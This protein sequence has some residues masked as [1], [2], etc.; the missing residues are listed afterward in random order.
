M[1]SVLMAIFLAIAGLASIAQAAERDGAA[2]DPFSVSIRVDATA[3]SARQA[4]ERAMAQGRPLAWRELFRRITRERDWATEPRLTD[5]ELLGLILNT[6]AVNERR[7]TT[8][9]LADVTFHFNPAAVRQVLFE[10]NIAFADG[11]ARTPATKGAIMHLAVNI[12]FKSIEDWATLR[13][14]L[15]AAKGVTGMEV[16]GRTLDEA[17]IYLSYSGDLDQLQGALEQ[18]NLDLTSAEGQYTLELRDGSE[19]KTAALQSR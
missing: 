15:P 16:V 10:H 3:P 8:R 17:Q 11:P 12:R 14:R 7:N 9:Y 18:Q 1:R 6:D 5:S 2:I 13:A 4:H 19:A